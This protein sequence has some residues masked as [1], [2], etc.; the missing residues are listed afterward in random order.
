[1]IEFLD[2]INHEK[3]LK[4]FFLN[5]FLFPLYPFNLRPTLIVLLL[6]FSIFYS[7]K[8][9][10]KF[11]LKFNKS[12]ESF[13]LNIG[14]FII[15][16]TGLLYSKNIS[17][18]VSVLFKML[19]LFI[20]PIIFKC[21]Y[22][23]R[24]ISE[25]L[26]L[27]AHSFFY[28]STFLLFLSFLVYFYFN[29]DITVNFLRNYNERITN[30]LGRYSIHPLYASIYISIAL[31]LSVKLLKKTYF[32]GSIIIFINTLLTLNLILLARKSTI[33][34]M[35]IFF[36]LY[37]LIFKKNKITM[38]LLLI[39]LVIT[40]GISI[41]IFVPDISYRF[42]DLTNF[43]ENPNGSIGLRMNTLKCG[44][45]SIFQNPILGYGIGDVKDVLNECYILFPKIFN[46]KYYNSHNQYISILL[47]SGLLG[48]IGL[49]AMLVHSF[50]ISI[51]FKNLESFA[52]L[53]LFSFM[54]FI[55]NILERQDGVLIFALFI[56]LF[57][58]T[59]QT[60][61]HKI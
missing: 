6:I 16:L 30:L 32:S 12:N 46:G 44:F 27:K 40:L 4:F 60:K 11:S 36:V 1:M 31:I 57:S 37:Q 41:F 48:F 45:A 20:F 51:K 15:L 21:I 56:N 34:I 39:L 28:L 22:D 9:K 53:L 23:V 47:S 49:I 17:A 38:S 5:I 26:I 43:I 42:N 25:K 58:F 18:G 54:M 10:I 14:F 61:N 33:I 55:E 24:H 3:L 35:F 52:I 59:N 13:Y 8:R 50:L 29:G 7:T 2:K 19:P